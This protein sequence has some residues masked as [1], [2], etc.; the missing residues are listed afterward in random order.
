M[1][2]DDKWINSLPNLNRKNDED[3]L[4]L[5][6]KYGVKPNFFQSALTW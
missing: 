4:S 3:L 2:N 5:I 1:I 6:D